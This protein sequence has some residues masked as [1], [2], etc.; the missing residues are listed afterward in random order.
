M[1][2]YSGAARDLHL[3]FF[4]CE[5]CTYARM[6]DFLCYTKDSGV[7]GVFLGSFRM[8][9]GVLLFFFRGV[10]KKRCLCDF[11]INLFHTLYRSLEI[12]DSHSDHSRHPKSPVSISSIPLPISIALSTLSTG[13][14]D[15]SPFSHDLLIQSHP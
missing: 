13:H 14:N 11:R 1:V 3:S 2:H 7:S 12:N 9:S 10:D 4:C 6:L 5:R 15:F 8:P